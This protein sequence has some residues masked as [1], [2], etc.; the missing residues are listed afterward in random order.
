[1]RC[2][3][4]CGRKAVQRH[5]VVYAQHLERGDRK[6]RRNLVPVHFECHGAHHGRSRPFSLHMLPSAVFAFAEEKL[7]AEAAYEYLKRYYAGSDMRHERLLL[8][9]NGMRYATPLDPVGHMQARQR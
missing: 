7:G 8:G 1:M 5:H 6:D 9:D 3:C 4:G 2:I